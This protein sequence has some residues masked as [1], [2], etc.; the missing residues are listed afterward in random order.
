MPSFLHLRRAAGRGI[1]LR[2]GAR[3]TGTL[4]VF[5]RRER[6]GISR[7]SSQKGD[8][9]LCAGGGE[10]KIFLRRR[11]LRP[12]GRGDERLVRSSHGLPCGLCGR[13]FKKAGQRHAGCGKEREQPLHG[14][15]YPPG[16][17]RAGKFYA[18]HDGR[19]GRG[20]KD[21]NDRLRN[22]LRRDEARRVQIR[23]QKNR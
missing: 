15:L 6:T 1:F 7:R 17:G 14:R 10:Q 18:D 5:P 2:H 22:T 13:I 3:G 19:G 4:R 8:E 16:K 11:G 9:G 21:G 12:F 23:I 20:G